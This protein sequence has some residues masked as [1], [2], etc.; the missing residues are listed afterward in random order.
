MLLWVW[1]CPQLCRVI[2]AFL[3]YQSVACCT[4]DLRHCR[5]AAACTAST[6]T[7]P[8]TYTNPWSSKG[9]P[10]S[11]IKSQNVWEQC[12][13]YLLDSQ[14]T[15]YGHPPLC[16]LRATFVQVFI[17]LSKGCQAHVL[18]SGESV[19]V[20]AGRPGVSMAQENG[21]AAVTDSNTHTPTGMDKPVV[22]GNT[23]LSQ[24]AQW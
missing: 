2:I 1:H 9:R 20:Q 24:T 18:I 8:P 15:G 3:H 6:G 23:R 11:I 4:A 7:V 10:D 21:G 17:V 14:N 22:G 5:A 16:H 12:P 19:T 13:F